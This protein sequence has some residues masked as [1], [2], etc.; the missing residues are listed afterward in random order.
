MTFKLPVPGRIVGRPD[1]DQVYV[2]SA[3]IPMGWINAVSLFQH[4]HRQ[5]GLAR[6]PCGAGRDP[7]KEWRRDKPVPKG[8]VEPSGTWFQYYLDD[9]DCPEKVPRHRWHGTHHFAHPWST[10]MVLR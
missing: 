8:A 2:A 3:V 9:F 4:L 10:A 7:A 1:R 5:A 6:E